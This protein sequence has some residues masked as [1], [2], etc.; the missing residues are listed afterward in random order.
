MNLK[1]Y[2]NHKFIL[3]SGY[4]HHFKC[5]RCNIKVYQDHHDKLILMNK[6]SEDLIYDIEILS[7][8]EQQIKNLLE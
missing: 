5:E 7:C 1:K 8:S 2:L 6:T 3:Y 4:S